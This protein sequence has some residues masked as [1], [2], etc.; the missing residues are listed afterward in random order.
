MPLMLR[1]ACCF[2]CRRYAV[3][4]EQRI[5]AAKDV[6][7][8]ALRRW[9]GAEIRRRQAAIFTRRRVMRSEVTVFAMLCRYCRRLIV[10]TPVAIRDSDITY[11]YTRSAV[12]PVYLFVFLP[13]LPPRR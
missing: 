13:S 7:F 4:K 9:R 2:V 1:A 6:S 10:A 5:Y 8:A 12:L 11:L 3:A